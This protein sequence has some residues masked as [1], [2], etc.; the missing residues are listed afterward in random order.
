M[1]GMVLPANTHK[2]LE[3]RTHHKTQLITIYSTAT[4]QSQTLSTHVKPL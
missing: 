4:A 3:V 1:D 2:M